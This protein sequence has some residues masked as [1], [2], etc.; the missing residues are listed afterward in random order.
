[1]RSIAGAALIGL[2]VACTPPQPRII[3]PA[4]ND[5]PVP[6][7]ELPDCFALYQELFQVP[8]VLSHGRSLAVEVVRPG[9]LQVTSGHVIVGDPVLLHDLQPIATRLPLG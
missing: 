7:T 9:D 6:E 4:P 1:M 8:M 2:C 5:R 3:L